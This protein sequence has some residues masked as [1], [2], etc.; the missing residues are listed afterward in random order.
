MTNFTPRV[1][2]G[3]PLN[4]E[5]RGVTG[6]SR[7]NKLKGASASAKTTKTKVTPKAAPVSAK[8]PTIGKKPPVIGKP[9][10]KDPDDIP[11]P[12]GHPLE[13]QERSVA[14]G[15]VN[16]FEKLKRLAGKPTKVGAQSTPEL[17][18]DPEKYDDIPGVGT[19]DNSAAMR[20]VIHERDDLRLSGEGRE[21]TLAKARKRPLLR[22]PRLATAPHAP[23]PQTGQEG[24]TARKER[25]PLDIVR[26]EA[27]STLLGLLALA[28]LQAH[29][30]EEPSL[31]EA[32]QTRAQE[33]ALELAPWLPLPNP[34]TDTNTQTGAPKEPSPM[35][36]LS[37]DTEKGDSSL[38]VAPV[39]VP[40]TG[41]GDSGADG[42]AGKAPVVTAK[43]RKLTAYTEDQEVDLGAFLELTS[44]VCND[45]P[46]SAKCP[47]FKEDH[48]CAY[49][50]SLEGLSSRDEENFLPAL[51]L[52][53]DVQFKR[54]RRAVMI[55]ARQTGGLLDPAVT[56]QV[57]V[58]VN[59]LERVRG[60]KLPV[61]QQQPSTTAAFVVQQTGQP[62]Q[63]GGGLIG[64]LM[65][66]LAPRP[67]PTVVPELTLNEAK[68]S[69]S[70][71]LA[72][73]RGAV[74]DAEIV[75]EGSKTA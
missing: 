30:C 74:I 44:V 2:K 66:S 23:T 26:E 52:L 33:T 38:A 47:K 45:C 46:I 19:E 58:A 61:V 3:A 15:Y 25:A 17:L 73:T 67:A 71:G 59:A 10:A 29:Y 57:E 43:P 50:E 8:P 11:P 5:K 69:E 41:R 18:F 70:Q 72:P 16:P 28:S 65:A 6:A 12:G 60:Y 7:N 34:G 48:T 39:P 4:I 9:R 20:K 14:E 27:A 55:E 32:L 54:A 68:S 36:G 53:A 42:A 40:L 62:A 1:R 51:E 21:D 49:E 63:E 64:K 31:R 75:P 56:K 37:S 24:T 13:L 35:G 22:P